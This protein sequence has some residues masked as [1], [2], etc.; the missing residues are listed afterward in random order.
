[1]IQI[2]LAS[3]F[4]RIHRPWIGRFPQAALT[5]RTDADCTPLSSSRIDGRGVP[6]LARPGDLLLEAAARH[7]PLAVVRSLVLRRT[8]VQGH[9]GAHTFFFE[10]KAASHHASQA[11]VVLGIEVLTFPDGSDTASHRA[12]VRSACLQMETHKD[13]VG[14]ASFC[15][16]NPTL[17]D[18]I[19][20][21]VLHAKAPASCAPCSRRTR[22]W[23]RSASRTARQSGSARAWRLPSRSRHAF[24]TRSIPRGPRHRREKR[25]TSRAASL[26]RRTSNPRLR[27]TNT[28]PRHLKRIHPLHQH[29]ERTATLLRLQRRPL[30]LQNRRRHRRPCAATRIRHLKTPTH[31]LAHLPATLPSL[32]TLRLRIPTF[33]RSTSGRRSQATSTSTSTSSRR[34]RTRPRSR[35]PPTRDPHTTH[36][37]DHPLTTTHSTGRPHCSLRRPCRTQ[38]A[39]ASQPALTLPLMDP[40]ISAPCSGTNVAIVRTAQQT[41][42]MAWTSTWNRWRRN[43]LGC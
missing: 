43:G 29:Q 17:T 1:M 25:S 4:I 35:T 2:S 31:P 13:S 34:R 37:L 6:V 23:R 9:F 30:T 28:I 27:A 41:T 19:M 10:N 8:H 42:L 36:S 33:N 22:S 40:T 20:Y 15:N 5:E 38:G 12:M 16:P 11:A 24:A 7:L 39:P 18:R 21:R 14:P 32:L 3:E 26:P